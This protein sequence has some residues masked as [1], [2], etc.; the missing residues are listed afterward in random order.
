LLALFVISM[1]TAGG[2]GASPRQQAQASTSPLTQDD[3]VYM[4]LTDRFPDGDPSNTD[5]GDGATRPGNLKYYQGGDWQGVIDRMPYIKSLG[6]T[7]I[8]ISPV[9]EQE[10][11]SRDGKEASYHGYFTKD[12]WDPNPHFGSKA[13]LK[14]LVDTAHANG[15]KVCIDAVPNH[16]ADYLRPYATGY[17]SADYQPDPPF[18][19]PDWYHHN[20]DTTDWNNQQQVENT[21]LGGLDDLA[22]E[23]PEVATELKNVY[24]MWVDDIGFDC[25][26]ID[27]ARSVPKWFLED[28]ERALAVPTFGEIFQGDPGYVSDY[29]NYEWS[30]LDFPLFFTAREVFASDADM[31]RIGNILAQ[32]YKYPNPNRLVTFIDNHDRDRFLTWADDNYQRLRV[33]LTFLF[34]VRGIPD[35]YYGTE[36]AYYGNGIGQEYQGIANNYN[37]E[38][39]RDFDQNNPIFKHIQRLAEVRKRYAP[40]R[41]GIQCE[42]WVDSTVYAFSRRIDST[43]EE[44]ITAVTNS[45]NPQTRTMPLRAESSIPVGTVLTN[46]LDTSD[47]VTVEAGGVTGKQIT[48][49]LGEHGGKIYVTGNPESYAPPERN[50]TRIRVHYDVGYGN[51]ITIRGSSYPLWWDRGRGAR[52]VAPGVWEWEMERIPAGERF[53][54]KLLIDD[55]TWSNGDNYVGYGGRTIDIYPTFP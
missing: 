37:R 42:M 4:L 14:E 36:Q 11:L 34:S 1:V 49:T 40:L 12:F 26:R 35:V 3:I 21:D 53:E 32:D 51:S 30:V 9:S 28:F 6:V 15:I 23:N 31:S 39:L 16:T 10:P 54:F 17:D 5:F 20:G 43:G 47:K 19:N 25:A 38:V 18:N 2:F 33:A 13:K 44:T 29:Q 24:G 27:A 55:T 41:L 48:V 45:W 50:I 7:A 46:V 8:W 52:N 22:Q